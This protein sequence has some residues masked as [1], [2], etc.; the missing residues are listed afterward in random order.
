MGDIIASA[1]KFLALV[2]IVDVKVRSNDTL[3][4]FTPVHD[5][6]EWDAV[7]LQRSNVEELTRRSV[8]RV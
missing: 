8:L 3:L 7:A 5:I 6:G 1:L 4:D 2:Q